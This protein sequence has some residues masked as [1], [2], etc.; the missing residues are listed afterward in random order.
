MKVANKAIWLESVG[1]GFVI[2]IPAL[3]GFLVQPVTEN[4]GILFLAILG[5]VGILVLF[6]EK[7]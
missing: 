1:I 3:V 4:I 6:E 7:R 5:L 2:V